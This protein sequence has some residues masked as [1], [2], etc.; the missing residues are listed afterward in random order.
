MKE[1]ILRILWENKGAYISGE[2][3]SQSLEVSRTAI[4][5]H[6]KSLKEEGYSIESSPRSGYCLVG[7]PDLLLP[8]ELKRELSTGWLGQEIHYYR[9]ID[10]TNS[11][12]KK[13]AA[14]GA[15]EGTTI[16]AEEQTAGKGRLGRQWTSPFGLGLW[17]SVILRPQITP[18]EAPKIT[19][20]VSVA[21]QEA[22]LEATGLLAKIKWPNDIFLE[23]RKI[24]GILL[25]MSG[26]MDSINHLIVGIGINVNLA[27]EDFPQELKDKAT[28]LKIELGKKVCRVSLTKLLLVKLEYY[29]NLFK[30]GEG[31]LLMEKWRSASCTLGKEVRVTTP[32]EVLE[33]QAV[34]FGED[35]SLLVQLSNGSLREIMAG[36]VTLRRE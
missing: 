21:L 33:G 23:D 7:Q 14:G 28:S 8:E 26:E 2:Q 31:S 30:Q 32:N 22:I 13:L 20:L 35:G 1:E 18:L 34:D 5:K 25:E 6:I 10:S 15:V 9:T 29:Y 11:L 36:D 24:A 17:L 19:M 27:Q 12:A 16:I 3:I 4:W